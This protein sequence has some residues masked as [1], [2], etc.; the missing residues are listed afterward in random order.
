[1][2]RSLQLVRVPIA[3]G[4]LPD[5]ATLLQP[6]FTQQHKRPLLPG[7]Y[8]PIPTELNRVQL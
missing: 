7:R 4:I 1:M 6:P 8:K 5:A 2:L 3:I